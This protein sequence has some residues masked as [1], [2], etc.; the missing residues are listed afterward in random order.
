MY[1]ET[2][3]GRF[4]TLG[5]CILGTLLV[6][7]MVV[8]LTNTT[9][10]TTGE[11]RVYDELVKIQV[12]N[13]TKKEASKLLLVLFQTFLLNKKLNKDKME[14]DEINELMMQKFGLLSKLKNQ[15]KI[16]KSFFKKFE[17]Y[18][19]SAEDSVIKMNERAIKKIDSTYSTFNKVP[20]I[21]RKC[22]RI[23]NDQKEIL[24]RVEEFTIFQECIANFLMKVNSEYREMEI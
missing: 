22:R 10:L 12:K 5:A 18:S 15:L 3:M 9:E 11:N 21:E 4:V 24:G 2:L 8:S 7:L 19:S 16:F 1:P 17:S 23:V 6:S 13:F 14:E 20:R